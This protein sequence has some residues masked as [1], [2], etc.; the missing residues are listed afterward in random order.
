MQR[1]LMGIAIVDSDAKDQL[2]IIYSAFLKYF[3]KNE[4]KRK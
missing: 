1:K 4:N 2:L 3:R